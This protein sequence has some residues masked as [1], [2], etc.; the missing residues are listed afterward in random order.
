MAPPT[1]MQEFEA[2]YLTNHQITGY[3]L[4]G[5]TQ[6]FPCPFCAA[7][8][9]YVVPLSDFNQDSPNL[10]CDDCGRS[11]QYQFARADGGAAMEI[12]QTGG[13][14][15]PDFLKPWPRRVKPR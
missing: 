8:E 6:H 11:A 2:L 10:K 7:P 4:D 14:D 15:P 1:N 13:D 9:W 5:V 12:V 3:G